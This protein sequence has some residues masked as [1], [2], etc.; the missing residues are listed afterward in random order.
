MARTRKPGYGWLFA[1]TVI[2]TLSAL[3][4]LMPQASAS[5]ACMLGYKAHCTFTP[6]STVI[7]AALA[8]AVCRLRKTFLTASE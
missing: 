1:L 3:S 2:F 5:R 4:T 8:G 7:C 6:V